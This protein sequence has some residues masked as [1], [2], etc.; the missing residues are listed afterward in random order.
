MANT[1]GRAH[2]APPKGEVQLRTF[3]IEHSGKLRALRTEEDEREDDPERTDDED[4]P[5][6]TD[7]EDDPER[8]DDEGDP[9][10]TDDE[11]DP[12]RTD[13]EDDPERTEQTEESRSEW[14]QQIQYDATRRTV[15]LPFSSDVPVQRWYGA[16]IL[17]HDPGAIRVGD[18]QKYMPLLY[19]HDTYSL[20][21]RVEGLEQVQGRLYGT[22]RFGKDQFGDW[23]LQQVL[24]E[25]LVN[26]SL[27]YE[28]YKWVED[29]EQ[30]SYTAIDW[31][32]VEFSMVTVPADATVGG[33]RSLGGGKN[34]STKGT[35]MK[36]NQRKQAAVIEQPRGAG[37]GDAVAK[38][39]ARIKE[40]TEL[41]RAHSVPQDVMQKMID[42]GNSISSVRGLVLS[43][44][45]QRSKDGGNGPVADLGGNP[46]PDLTDAEKSRYS[47]IR[48]LN[49]AI[50]GDWKKAGFEREVSDEIIKRS[51]KELSHE[52]AFMV[53]T[54]LRF[55]ARRDNQDQRDYNT[56]ALATGGALV[57]T[58]LM[59][60]SFIEMLRN[61]AKV[62]QL[63]AT[64]LSGLVGNVDIPK[65]LTGAA[66]GWFTEGSDMPKTSGTFG[67][68]AL[69]LKSIG[70]Y[71]LITRNMLLQSTPDIEMIVRAD[72]IA[73]LALGID[74]AALS[75]TGLS[76]QPL[77]IANTNGINSIIGG[78]NG[79]NITLD[80][81][82][83]METAVEDANADVG[84]LAY[85][86]N[87]RTKG[88]LKK[89]K[90]TTGQYLWTTS[91]T[92]GRSATPGE[93]NGHAA[94][95]TNQARKN[96]TKGTS[97]GI[98]SELFF[99]AWSEVLIGEWGALEILPNPY[100]EDAFA[101]GG[102]LIRA[103]HSVDVG[104][105]HA[106]AFSVMSDALTP[107]A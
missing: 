94:A 22:V 106:S 38:E 18:R 78:T 44:I 71:S 46:S 30:E 64:V 40:I 60:G 45:A 85:L 95:V 21:G 93:L 101:S 35:E 103:A 97:A 92:G 80:H 53:P 88:Y 39:R 68:V 52:N 37:A 31:E 49:A 48:A 9:E 6:R 75:G 76:G 77:G 61:K 84:S 79:A 67:K 15:R 91:P 29:V 11:D 58:D 16:E 42:D 104:V 56:G 50:S 2:K 25:V 90:S 26:V 23:A 10:R 28:V 98:C 74:L 14:L 83:D 99:G 57:A 34:Q 19:N 32:P 81:I 43:S 7:D 24:D 102:L 59:Y 89:A 3:G 5:E 72:L 63:G 73:T 20:L 13:D 12:E 27:R 107:Q 41:C 17:S 96:L 33:G 8:T 87:P 105:R 51:G 70:T 62:M 82:I 66:P 100:H 1:P 36:L 4:D 54:N 69:A 86:V 55:A 47:M 65:Q